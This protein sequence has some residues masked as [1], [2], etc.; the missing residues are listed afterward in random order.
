VYTPYSP[1]ARVDNAPESLG[2]AIGLGDVAAYLGSSWRTILLSAAAFA[3]IAAVYCVVTSPAF[4]A[5]AQLMIDINKSQ[6]FF[7]DSRQPERVPDQARVESQMEV[8][9]SD[10]VALAVIRELNLVEDPEFAMPAPSFLA[11]VLAA[12]T[13][14]RPN[15]DK[16]AK[17]T[18]AADVFDD[19][20]SVRRV[21]QSLVIEVAFRSENPTKA[22][23]IANAITEAYIKQ[24]VQVKS[25]AAQRGGKWLSERLDELRQQADDA[26]RAYERFKLVGDKESGGEPQVKLAELESISQSYRNMYDF[27]LT[28]FTE[29]MQKVSFPESDA[30]VVSAAAV[31]LVK[32]FPKSKLIV[33]FAGLLGIV[34]GTAFSWAR[35]SMDR[36]IR[37]AARLTR[38]TGLACLG[39]IRAWAGT[40]A[41]K[42][43]ITRVLTLPWYRRNRAES[44]PVRLL[45]LAAREPSSPFTTD[46][47]SLKNAI[48]NVMAGRRSRCI[49]VVAARTGEGT[50]TVAANLSQVC[51]ASGMRTLLID[52]CVPNPTVSKAVSTGS[53]G[54]SEVLDNPG[55]LAEIIDGSKERTLSVLPVGNSNGQGTPGDRIGSGKTAMHVEDLGDRFDIVVFDLPALGQSPDALAIA[56]YLDGILLVADFASTS[57]DLVATAAAAVEATRGT[58]LGVAINKVPARET[59]K[60]W[61]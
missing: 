50:T 44:R 49:G 7:Q 55:L 52:A 39:T 19:L 47:R 12:L 22:A 29:T 35:Y 54:L 13:G 27:F 6:V 18:Y 45:G 4:T 59:A 26:L 21:G 37:S 46:I 30:R 38:E 32:S 56:P 2:A 15:S 41:R 31:P 61:A 36:S 33:A 25:E 14:E 43:V 10:R 51:A 28:Q 40:A 23:T 3:A 17:E 53:A 57:L 34:A 5:R 58:I 11:L 1:K 9:K 20:L 8:L 60:E 16:A 24:D 42:A 48:N